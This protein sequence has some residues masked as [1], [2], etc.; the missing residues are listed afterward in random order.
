MQSQMQQQKKQKILLK[1]QIQRTLLKKRTLSGGQ[2]QRIAIARDLITDPVI[3]MTDEAIS[4]SASEKKVQI[5]ATRTSVI[6]AHRS[7]TVKN[8]DR[9]Y[10]FDTGVIVER[11]TH[12]EL[13]AKRQFY[14][15]IVKRQLKDVEDDQRKRILIQRNKI[16]WKTMMTVILAMMKVTPLQRGVQIQ[17]NKIITKKKI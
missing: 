14:Y 13:I 9:I 6:V 11:G 1:W 15:E 10:A 2:I 3:L 7:T 16:I 8:A 17:G 12:K 5:M 4:D